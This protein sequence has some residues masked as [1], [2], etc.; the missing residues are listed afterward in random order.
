MKRLDREKLR[1]ITKAYK[2]AVKKLLYFNLRETNKEFQRKVN[3]NRMVYAMLMEDLT[4]ALDDNLG[5]Y[6][7]ISSSKE[8]K[9]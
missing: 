8:K 6:H 3:K 7:I 1:Y 2:K 4:Y 5:K 9:K